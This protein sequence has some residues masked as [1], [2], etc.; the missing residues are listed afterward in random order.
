MFGNDG[1]GFA[2]V[3]RRELRKLLFCDKR[4]APDFDVRYSSFVAPSLH[5]SRASVDA[6]GDLFDG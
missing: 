3:R 2:R 1:F 6:T 4:A 5:G